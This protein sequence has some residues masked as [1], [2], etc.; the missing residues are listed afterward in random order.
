MTIV[1]LLWLEV[2]DQIQLDQDSIID[3][4]D[5]EVRKKR[6]AQI[7]RYMRIVGAKNKTSNLLIRIYDF[8]QK[9]GSLPAPPDPLRG[10]F[11][12]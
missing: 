4:P 7:A 9:W 11:R 12:R 1:Y 8:R 2:L 6:E 3:D 5:P 10:S